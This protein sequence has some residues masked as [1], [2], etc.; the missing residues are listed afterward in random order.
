VAVIDAA[1]HGRHARWRR[2]DFT[3]DLLQRQV[4]TELL[5]QNFTHPADPRLAN[6]LAVAAIVA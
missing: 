3:G 5:A 2:A 6:A 1:K 4:R